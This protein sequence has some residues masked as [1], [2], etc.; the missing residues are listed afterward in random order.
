MT[1]L[2]MN[3]FA[4]T[5]VSLRSESCP[6]VRVITFFCQATGVV[7][8]RNAVVKGSHHCWSG[9]ER[10]FWQ[11]KMKFFYQYFV[12]EDRSWAMNLRH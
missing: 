10:L 3:T 1:I 4:F 8:F 11:R 7:A 2:T 12:F 9:P 6:R 5:S